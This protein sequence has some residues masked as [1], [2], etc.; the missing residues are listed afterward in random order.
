ML[1]ESELTSFYWNFYNWFF[2]S[3]F[4]LTVFTLWPFL[5]SLVRSSCLSQMSTDIPLEQT[6]R[7]A[8]MSQ[9]HGVTLRGSDCLKIFTSTLPN[10]EGPLGFKLLINFS[11]L[12]LFSCLSA[13][14]INSTGN[15]SCCIIPGDF[16]LMIG[17]AEMKSGMTVWMKGSSKHMKQNERKYGIWGQG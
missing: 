8:N 16:L 1:H 10:A 13:S 14:E 7:K 11:T 4:H 15:G 9:R 17:V 12:G 3:L 2:C 5:L 6:S